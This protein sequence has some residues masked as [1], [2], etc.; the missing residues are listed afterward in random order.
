MSLYSYVRGRSKVTKKTQEGRYKSSPA[1]FSKVISL[2]L[3]LISLSFFGY[4]VWVYSIWT[5]DLPLL[6]LPKERT[7]PLTL[8][9]SENSPQYKQSF[10]SSMPTGQVLGQSS[11]TTREEPKIIWERFYLNIPALQIENAVVTTNVD[12]FSK[13]NYLPVLKNSLAHYKGTSLPG[14]AGDVFIYGHSV[15]PSFFNPKDYSAIFS[16]LDRLKNGDELTV[17]WGDNLY[18]YK[19]IGSQVVNPEDVGIV[20]RSLEGEKTLSL[21]TCFPPGLKTKRIIVTAKQID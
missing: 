8:I 7:Q 3:I 12:S 13:E 1:W 5:L 6:D 17:N 15:L 2:S 19:V 11:M 10:N 14:E 4:L 16:T 9:T 20:N 18:K 21:M